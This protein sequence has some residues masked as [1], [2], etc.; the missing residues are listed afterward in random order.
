[1]TMC[2]LCRRN[3]LVGERYRI[4]RSADVTGDRPVCRLCE[5]LAEEIGWVRADEPP[6]RETGSVIWHARKVA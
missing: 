5:E 1:M 6:Q 2:L 4:W 3:L